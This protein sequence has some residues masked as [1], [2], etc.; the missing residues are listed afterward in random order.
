MHNSRPKVLETT[1]M[2]TSSA[3]LLKISLVV[4]IA[5]LIAVIIACGG[6]SVNDYLDQ[7]QPLFKQ[8]ND[9]RDVVDEVARAT[10]NLRTIEQATRTVSRVMPDLETAIDKMNNAYKSYGNLEIPE[11]FEEHRRLT[12][13]AWRAGIEGSVQISIYF[14]EFL[15]GVLESEDAI[16]R[17]N[18]LF[19]EE[20]MHQLAARRA[21]QDAR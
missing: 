13:M 15:A 5:V 17:A 7:V 11:K 10:S 4:G 14:Q 3:L 2:T 1:P 16:F 19:G 6:T 12:L 21:L 9:A 8:Y 18:G 20:D